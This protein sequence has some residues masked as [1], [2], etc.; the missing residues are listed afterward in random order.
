M[1]FIL[2]SGRGSYLVRSGNGRRRPPWTPCRSYSRS[3]LSRVASGSPGGDA[4]PGSGLLRTAAGRASSAASQT[5]SISSDAGVADAG[6]VTRS[7]IQAM[8]PRHDDGLA[9]RVRPRMD[10]PWRR[11]GTATPSVDL[12]NLRRFLEDIP[13]PHLAALPSPELA[14]EV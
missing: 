4:M 12:V 1:N 6:P 2:D 8:S 5:K 9:P 7:K 11:V 13:L 3:P 10:S 14:H